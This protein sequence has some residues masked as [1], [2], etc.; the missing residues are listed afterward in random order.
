VV[1]HLD[2]LHRQHAGSWRK[3]FDVVDAAGISKLASVTGDVDLGTHDG[4][5]MAR[6][7][8]AVSAE[9]E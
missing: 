8:G 9:G 3:F 7:L 6:I 5:F 4:R 2:R 1:W